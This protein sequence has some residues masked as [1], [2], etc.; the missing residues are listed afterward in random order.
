MFCYWKK[1]SIRSTKLSHTKDKKNNTHN[2][3]Y[4]TNAYKYNSDSDLWNL[5][6]NATSKTKGKSTTGLVISKPTNQR[7][8]NIFRRKSRT[9][10]STIN[11]LNP[12]IRTLSTRYPR[13]AKRIRWNPVHQAKKNNRSY[14]FSQTQGLPSD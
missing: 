7:N 2:W 8:I 13:L 1:F 6:F 5:P 10:T 9:F 14:T 3:L 11:L 4:N 12:I